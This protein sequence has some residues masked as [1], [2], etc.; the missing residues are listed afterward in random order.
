[1][2]KKILLWCLLLTTIT[3]ALH[4][5]SYYHTHKPLPCVQ[6]KFTIVAQIVRDTVGDPGI[7]T[8]LIRTRIEELNALFAPVC[9]SFEI[10]EFRYIDNFQ[11]NTVFTQEEWQEMQVK[12]HQHNRINMFFVETVALQ[13]GETGYANVGS[14]ADLDKEGLIIQKLNLTMN[15]MSLVHQ[16]GHYFGLLNTCEGNGNELVNGGNCAIAGDLI[17]D[18]PADPYVPGAPLDQYLSASVA[19]RYINKSKDANNEYYVPD[20]GNAMA[21]YECGCG[22]S[23][24]QYLKMVNTYQ[25][26]D[27][28][29]W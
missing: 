16:M 15:V 19:C 4:S 14:I 18:T 1:M 25:A 12:Y 29:M 21:L 22:F 11:Y 5:Q 23:Y 9:M 26:S 13:V 2:M 10:C 3:P 20:V 27:P 24:E 7:D 28:K 17:C 6:K 8:T